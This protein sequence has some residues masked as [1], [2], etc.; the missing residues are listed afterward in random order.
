M[1]GVIKAGAGAL[2]RADRF[3]AKK[4]TRQVRT[5]LDD[6][7]LATG[8]RRV[9]EQFANYPATQRMTA[10]LEGVQAF[11]RH[12]PTAYV[13][14]NPVETENQNRAFTNVTQ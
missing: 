4:L 6:P 8:A 11:H 9:A 10:F 7:A 14:R 2:L 1:S 5:M 12:A 13:E 3:R